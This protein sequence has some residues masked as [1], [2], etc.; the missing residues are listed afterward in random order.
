MDVLVVASYFASSSTRNSG[1]VAT[2][3]CRWV[4]GL[5]DK[6][7]GRTMLLWMADVNGDFGLTTTSK[8]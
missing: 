6:H 8:E 7:G 5:Y 4:E 1:D 3:I 2:R